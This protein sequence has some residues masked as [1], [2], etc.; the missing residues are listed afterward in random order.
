MSTRSPNNQRYQR[1]TE[2]AGQSRKSA[3]SAKPKMK[4]GATVTTET[5]PTTRKEKREQ[6]AKVR[7]EERKG[8]QRMDSVGTPPDP[9]YKRWR[10]W[11]WVLLVAAIVTTALSWLV[12]ANDDSQFTLYASYVSLGLAYAFIIAAI[13]LDFKKIRPIRKQWQY[14]NTKGMSKKKLKERQKQ[15]EEAAT[16]LAAQKQAKAESRKSGV[17]GMVGMVGDRIASA[18]PG[19]SKSQPTVSTDKIGEVDELL[20]TVE[21]EAANTSKAKTTQITGSGK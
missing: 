18:L 15:E 7:A 9:E 2:V 14:E 12:R 4:A 8:E 1:D 13:V 3:T 5:K 20:K 21:Q 11:W 6:R 19:K 16:L 17:V 10:R